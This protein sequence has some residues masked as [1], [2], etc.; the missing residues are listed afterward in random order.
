MFYLLMATAKNPKLDSQRWSL[1]SIRTFIALRF[2]P[3]TK[4][5]GSALFPNRRCLDLLCN[6]QGTIF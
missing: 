6:F 1:T 3:N 5:A 4:A 2:Y